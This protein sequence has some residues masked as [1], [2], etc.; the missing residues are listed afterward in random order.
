MLQTQFEKL[1][2]V[3]A[4]SVNY[5]P[6]AAIR[7]ELGDHHT[8]DFVEGHIP[9]EMFPQLR[10]VASST[11]EFFSYA[12]IEDLDSCLNALDLLDA[13]VAAEGPFDG[14]LAFSQGAIIAS[15]YLAR[16]ALLRPDSASPFKCA[17]FF[18]APAA[19]SFHALENGRFR[20]MT[21]DVDGELIR[22]PTAHIWGS[23]D[24]SIDAATVSSLCAPGTMEV[25]V[26]AGGHEVPGVRMNAAVK[27]SVQIIRR[28]V[29]MA[30][31]EQ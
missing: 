9:S 10:E 7:F 22:I 24:A 19:Y 3:S 5:D 12:D 23:N 4:D 11:D 8:Y 29:S 27:S 26:H 14:I 6:T 17:V 20:K 25:Y 16:R 31:Y 15:S 13:Y 18:S 21:R 28:V 2:R 1:S 30:G